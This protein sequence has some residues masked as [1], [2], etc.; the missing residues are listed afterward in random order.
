ML[1]GPGEEVILYPP[2]TYLIGQRVFRLGEDH[3]AFSRE[4]IKV[5]VT[6][7]FTFF[8]RQNEVLILHVSERPFGNIAEQ[9]I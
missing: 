8:K 2:A 9:T 6:Q 3:P 1:L 4:Q 5:D 7:P